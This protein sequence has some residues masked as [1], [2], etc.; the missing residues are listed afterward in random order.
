MRARPPE[1]VSPMPQPPPWRAYPLGTPENV[2]GD[3]TQTA[4][5]RMHWQGAAAVYPF[6][7]VAAPLSFVSTDP[8]DSA[9][10]TGCREV[11]IEWLDANLLKR[12]ER[13]ATNGTTPVVPGEQALR[14][15]RFES[16]VAGTGGFNA[17]TMTALVGASVLAHMVPNYGSALGCLRSTPVN[18]QLWI[19]DAYASPTNGIFQ[20]NPDV[21][22]LYYNMYTRNIQTRAVQ[23]LRS[24]RA[25]QGTT[26]IVGLGQLVP[27]G[28][29]VWWEFTN[30]GG[31]NFSSSIQYEAHWGAPV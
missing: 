23:R 19:G 7:T 22:I 30:F 9:G 15:N 12:V 10:G 24:A 8:Q 18:Q 28:Y 31:V 13:Y 5:T 25:L 11:E 4:G 1:S 17:G 29:D 16:T 2:L 26:Q 3:C 6:P 27:P 21:T 14:V 20:S